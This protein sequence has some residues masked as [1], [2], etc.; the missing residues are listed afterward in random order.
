MALAIGNVGKRREAATGGHGGDGHATG[1][2]CEANQKP[3]SHDTSRKSVGQAHG[4]GGGGVFACMSHLRRRHPADCVQTAFRVRNHP[5]PS[6]SWQPPVAADFLSANQGRS[7]RFC[8]TLANRSN[9]LRFLP[10]VARL[11]TGA[12]SCRCTTT[13]TSF[14]R[15]MPITRPAVRSTRARSLNRS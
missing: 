1:G 2:C 15:H 9:R 11:P 12:N 10:H 8:P 3:R 7:G 4:E 14:K 5:W 13:A 6:H